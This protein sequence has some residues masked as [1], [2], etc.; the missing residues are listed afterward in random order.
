MP[1]FVIRAVNGQAPLGSPELR[2]FTPAV[3]TAEHESAG[4]RRRRRIHKRTR[5]Q[6]KSTSSINI[7]PPLISAVRK[8]SMTR[9]REGTDKV[10]RAH[11]C[12]S[13]PHQH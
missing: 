5:E 11:C 10:R 2:K 6:I 12:N 13:N 4:D 3:E 9:R 7:A 1:P 8:K